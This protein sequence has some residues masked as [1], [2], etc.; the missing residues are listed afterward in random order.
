MTRFIVNDELVQGD[1]S[2]RFKQAI[3]TLLSKSDIRKNTISKLLSPENMEC[4]SM[5]F[6]HVSFDANNNYEYYEL[7]GD[8]IVNNCIVLFLKNKFPILTSPKYIRII[9]RLK[10]L[11]QSKKSFSDIMKELDLWDFVSASLSMK[12]TRKK[13]ISEDVFEAFFGLTFL[14]CE[15]HYNDSGIAFK[16]CYKITNNMF[17]NVKISL[18]YEDVF[19]AKS[20]LKELFDNLKHLGKLEY[21]NRSELVNGSTIHHV[22]ILAI[23]NGSRQCIGQSS[24]PLLIDAQQV[25]SSRALSHLKNKGISRDTPQTFLDLYKDL[26]DPPPDVKQTP[27]LECQK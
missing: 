14:L 26:K 5:A 17:D 21:S 2:E 10:N 18:R 6:T 27:I 4:Y 3:S 25:A 19:D 11:L 13:R 9:S 23:N 7:I 22:S 16:I 1:R 8:S 15:K 12:T 24:G 20:R